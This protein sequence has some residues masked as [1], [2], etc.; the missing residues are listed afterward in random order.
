MD[1]GIVAVDLRADPQVRRRHALGE[2]RVV[3]AAHARARHLDDVGGPEHLARDVQ[4]ARHRRLVV[5][6]HRRELG[7]LELVVE[8]HPGLEAVEDPAH[9]GLHRFAVSASSVRTEAFS[10]TEDAMMLRAVPP[11]M[12]PMVSTAELIGAISRLT[13]VCT[14]LTKCAAPTI[15]ST[16]RCGC[17][18]CPADALDRHVERIGRRHHGFRMP[19]DGARRKLR[20]V[21][22]AEDRVRLRRRRTRPPS[23]IA[24]RAASTSPRR[25]GR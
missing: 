5:A 15:A 6:Q 1:R 2:P 17:A 4:H 18:P 13:M 19:A 10:S 23:S 8:A 20:P 21:V 12:L 22:K 16:A 14:C 24:A 7:P 25:A 11:W 3:L 9:R